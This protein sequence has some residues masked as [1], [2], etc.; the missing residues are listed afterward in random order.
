MV[1][2]LGKIFV[3]DE[4]IIP[5]EHYNAPLHTQTGTNDVTLQFNYV[6]FRCQNN[7]LIL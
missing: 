7:R 3:S 2:S 4:E 1:F 6:I 5:F